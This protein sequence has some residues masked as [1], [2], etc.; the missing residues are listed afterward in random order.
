MG[1]EIRK[2][3]YMTSIMSL[4]REQPN[5]NGSELD[6]TPRRPRPL[7]AERRRLYVVTAA[8]A[9]ECTCPEFCERDHEND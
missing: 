3:G 7:D 4:L 5:G 8:E 1:S 6:R 2:G 9:A